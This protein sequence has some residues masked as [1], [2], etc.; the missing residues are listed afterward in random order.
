MLLT[1][2]LCEHLQEHPETCSLFNSCLHT[3]THCHNRSLELLEPQWQ[4]VTQPQG[5]V[6][7]IPSGQNESQIYGKR[8]DQFQKQKQKLPSWTLVC[9]K[10]GAGRSSRPP[11][12]HLNSDLSDQNTPSV[13]SS[14]IYRRGGESQCCGN[15]RR[16]AVLEEP[17][18][19]W[20]RPSSMS[21]E[22]VMLF[23]ISSMEI[24]VLRLI[25]GSNFFTFCKAR[26]R[27][28]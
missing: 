28:A 16:E 22:L 6:H 27:D 26:F 2:V 14:D 25:W 13:C 17:R 10:H 8:S 5:P 12:S 9:I 3:L 11:N 21:L 1:W 7:T 18:R 4:A 19:K 15:S 24:C 20:W 23:L